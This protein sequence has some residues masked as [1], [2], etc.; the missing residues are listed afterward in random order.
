[1]SKPE[2]VIAKKTISQ[3][4]PCFVIAEMGHNHQ[5]DLKTALQMIDE[6]ARCGAHAV[7]LQKRFNKSLYTM[8]MYNKQYE[9]E[10]SFGKTYGEH[11]EK[12][13]FGM[14]EYRTLQRHAKK[15]GV[16]FFATAFDFQSVDFL[17]ELGV[18]A[19]KIASGDVT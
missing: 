7:K 14:N 10:N 5:G 11:R 16:V 13:E 15:R 1:M 4:S 2:L 19:Y 3:D 12:L 18:P 6:A 8:E 9:N 17:E